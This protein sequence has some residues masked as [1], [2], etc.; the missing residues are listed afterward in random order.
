MHVYIM[1]YL[2][3]LILV[4]H[5]KD[6]EV[7]RGG[8]GAAEVGRAVLVQPRLELGER[9]AV[10]DPVRLCLELLLGAADLRSYARISGLITNYA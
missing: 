5:F 10:R 2:P 4:E 9:S 1:E 6:V 7:T 3:L 8:G